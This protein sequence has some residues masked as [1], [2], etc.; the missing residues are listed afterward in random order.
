MNTAPSDRPPATSSPGEQRGYQRELALLTSLFFMWGFITCLNDILIPKLKAIFALSYAEAMLVNLAFFGAYAVFS[1]PS[2]RIVA[3][4]GYQRGIVIGLGTAGLGCAGFY[5]A[6]AALSYPLFLGTL[7]VLACGITLL[8]VSANPYVTALGPESSGSARLTLTQAFNSL[9][10]T[11]APLLGARLI[12][13]AEG[14]RGI[15]AVQAS[16]LGLALA[17]LCLAAV[18]ALARLPRVSLEATAE[19]RG[20]SAWGHRHLVLGAVGIFVYV[21]GEVAIGSFLVNYFTQPQIGAMS[22]AQAGSYVAY[23]W[24]GAMVG[25]FVGALV[26]RHVE[27]PRVLAAAA[28]VA[29]ALLL[30]TMQTSGPAAVYSILAIGLCNSIMFPSIFSLALRG[31]GGAASQ[32]SGILCTAIVGGAL[33]PV[34]EGA[35]ADRVGLQRAFVVPLLCYAYIIFYGMKGSRP[36]PAV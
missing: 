34:L 10:T 19:A 27:T 35:L 26:L 14:A 12:L 16:Y 25:R 2:G 30:T 11:L 21:G 18:M 7:F 28:A 31:L 32:G 23:Y 13:G 3:R 8:Q 29:C 9:G 20:P 5:P 6:A 15:G 1:L 36:S 24:G 33:I 4:V 22:E 17:L